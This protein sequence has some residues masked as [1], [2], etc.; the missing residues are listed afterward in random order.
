MLRSLIVRLFP[1]WFPP[2]QPTNPT[3]LNPQSPESVS[4][5]EPILPLEDT[6]NSDVISIDDQEV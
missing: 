4:E 2:Q 3:A 1:W 5:V 6:S